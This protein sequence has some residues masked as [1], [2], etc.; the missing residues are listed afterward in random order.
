VIR[1]VV[2]TLI[3][4]GGGAIAPAAQARVLRVGPRAQYRRP[5]QAT[6]AARPGDRIEIDARGDRFYRGDVCAWTTNRLT[7][8]GVHGRPH[9]DA[10]GRNSEGK[11]IWVIAGNDTTIE[12]IEFS[13]ARVS[14]QKGAAIRQEGATWSSTTSAASRCATAIRPTPGSGTWSSRARCAITSCTTGSP[15]SAGQTATSSTSRTVASRTSS[16]P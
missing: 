4:L 2:I 5:C 1:A 6:A 7:I 13:G 9:I 8:V 16:A 11:A 15:A 10:A 3:A 12:N 14:D